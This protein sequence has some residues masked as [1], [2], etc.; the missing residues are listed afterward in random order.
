[1]RIR[2]FNASSHNRTVI[3]FIN[4]NRRNRPL[5]LL[6]AA[7]AGEFEQ[8]VPIL[9]RL[10]RTRFFILLS[11]MSPTIFSKQKKTD[12]AD[13]VV[14]HPMDFWWLA[15]LFFQRIKPNVYVVNR[16]DIW[17]SHLKIA[18]LFNIKTILINANLHEKS[19]RLIPIFRTFNQFVFNQFDLICTGTER[20][21]KRLINLVPEHKIHVTGDTRVNRVIER[22]NKTELRTEFEHYSSAKNIILGS[23]IESDY[24]VVFKGL[25]KTFPAGQVD[26]EKKN[27]KL[28]IVPHEPDQ[29]TITGI[30]KILDKWRV[31]WI[32]L[33]D[34]DGTKIEPALIVDEVGLLA[35]IY[36]IGKCSYVG[37]G[38]GAGVHSVI[39]PAIYGCP[40]SFGPNIHILDE[41]IDLHESDL[42]TMVKSSKDFIKFLTILDDDEKYEETADQLK[43]FVQNRTCEIHEII[44]AITP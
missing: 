27:V 13:A 21:K 7:S 16:H 17:P 2:L 12:L 18:K 35:D 6:H 33:S 26:L 41:A 40:V 28:I 42:G 9:N 5:I 37:A 25:K 36:K 32:P 44:Q 4:K 22:M 30:I 11:L 20:L 1:M 19:L 24:D 23:I 38:F 31:G 29:P 3:Y 39:E 15:F 8:L 34:F 10:D 43:A 14:Y